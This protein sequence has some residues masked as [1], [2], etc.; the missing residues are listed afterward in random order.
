MKHSFRLIP[1]SR[2]IEL[3]LATSERFRISAGVD[4]RTVLAALRA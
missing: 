1:P 3:T 2:S 4:E